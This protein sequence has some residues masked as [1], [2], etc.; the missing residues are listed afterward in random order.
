MYVLVDPVH[1]RMEIMVCIYR[2]GPN[3]LPAIYLK[4]VTGVTAI[5]RLFQF[6]G[7]GNKL[8]YWKLML[9]RPLAERSRSQCPD[10]H[11]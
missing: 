5:D 3:G 11:C 6:N 2:L 9:I 7:P 8:D 1:L 10:I 4:R